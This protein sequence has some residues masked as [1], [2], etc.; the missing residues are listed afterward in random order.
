MSKYFTELLGNIDSRERVGRAIMEGNL[1]HAFL[2]GGPVGSGKRSFAKLI[3]AAVNCENKNAENSLPC[4]KCNNCRRIMDESFIDLKFFAKQKDR[5]TIGVDDMR[6]L[7]ED[8]MLS[9]AESSNKFYIIEDAHCL[10]VESQNALLNILEEPPRGVTV[11]L[12]ATEC[13]RILTTIKSRVQYIAMTRFSDEEIADYV[14]ANV[15]EARDVK[16]LNPDKFAALVKN[17]EGVIG[18][19]LNLF[20]KTEADKNEDERQKIL[21]LIGAMTPK[22]SYLKLHSAISALPNKRPELMLMLEKVISAVRDLIV[23]KEAKE[24]KSIFFISEDEASEYIKAISIKKLLS[25]Y[26][27]LIK[28]HEYCTKNANVGTILADLES[29]IKIS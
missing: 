4:L 11:I 16:R 29:K 6:L 12:L 22:S 8:A 18:K 28:A 23:F 15:A 21:S 14:V 3:A 24:A 13:D 2:L 7:K 20:R 19:A 5:A 17:A 9:G 1:P 25:I 10:T 26:D 27:A